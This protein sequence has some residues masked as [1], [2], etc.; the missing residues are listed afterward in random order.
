MK[1]FRVSATGSL[2]DMQAGVDIGKV[3]GGYFSST[4]NVRRFCEVGLMPIESMLP[5][6]IV[7]VDFGGGQGALTAEVVRAL[8]EKG[9]AVKAI[10]VDSNE[11]FLREA[12]ARGFQTTLSNLETCEGA[13]VNLITM[14]AVLHYNNASVQLEILKNAYRLLKKGGYLI[15]QVSSGTEENCRLR[16]AIV[17][18]PELGRGTQ[19]EYH[20][21][22]VEETHALHVQAGFEDTK[23]AGDAPACTWG[24]EE[25][26]ERFNTKRTQEAQQANNQELLSVIASER[27]VYVEAANTLIRTALQKDGA[28]KT[29]IESKPDGTYLIHYRYPIFVSR[30]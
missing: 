7:Y 2:A 20:W 9:H 12:Q 5:K 29:G 6:Q 18:I 11:V 4:E 15:H 16:S 30:K 28:E 25:Q 21:T 10:V 26:W 23:I 24:P 3:F 22:S 19:G 8:K 17:N 1:P 14:R 13:E 27:K